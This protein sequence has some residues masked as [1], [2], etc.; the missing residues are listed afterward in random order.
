MEF[1][2]DKPAV[3]LSASDARKL[4]SRTFDRSNVNYSL[5][6]TRLMRIIQAAAR[7]GKDFIEFEAPSFVLDGSLADPIVLARQLK[8]KLQTMGYTVTRTESHLHIS[9]NEN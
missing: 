5:T 9:W 4:C 1:T 8:K 7:S 3:M 6:L 2:D